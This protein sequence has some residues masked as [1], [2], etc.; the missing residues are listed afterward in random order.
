[1]KPRTREPQDREDEVTTDTKVGQS[2]LTTAN[3]DTTKSTESTDMSLKVRGKAKKSIEE[4]K[5]S[6]KLMDSRR[7][8]L[9]DDKLLKREEP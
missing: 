6:V 1:V 2:L 7:L 3:T 8:V 9:R 4:E 5:E